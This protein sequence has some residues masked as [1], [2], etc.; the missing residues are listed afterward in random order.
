MANPFVTS[1]S[2]DKPAYA[3]G[4]LVTMTVVYGDTDTKS[5]TI[6]FKVTDASGNQA[7]GSGS[8]VV[9]PLKTEVIDPAGRVWT[10]KSDTGTITVFTAVA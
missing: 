5:Q 4:A 3:V 9:D 2:F 6:E 1:V 8:F 7:T 10:K